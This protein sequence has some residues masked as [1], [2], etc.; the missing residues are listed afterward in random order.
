[1]TDSEFN[2]L[3]GLKKHINA[4][5]IE[6]PQMGELGK[7]IPVVSDTTTDTFAIDADRRCSIALY[8]HKLQE[9]YLNFPENMVR[10]EINGRPHTNPDGTVLSRNHIH[11][12]SEQYGLSVA[13][14]LDSVSNVLFKDLSSFDKI[15]Y[16]FC[17]F[18]NININNTQIQGVI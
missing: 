1:M 2:A 8:R 3:M 4:D 18:C 15:F 16:D 13:Y 12:F 5:K 9:R 11:I 10:L 6:L 17:K 14:E 7:I